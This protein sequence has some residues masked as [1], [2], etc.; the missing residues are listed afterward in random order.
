MPPSSKL[1]IALDN[2]ESGPIDSELERKYG[3]RLNALDTNGDGFVDRSELLSFIRD[4][5]DRE[6]KYKNLKLLMIVL[7]VL[8][9]L[10]ALTTFGTVWAVVAL[11]EKI[12][13]SDATGKGSDTVPALVSRSTGDTLR[14][15]MGYVNLQI[16]PRNESDILAYE[17]FT[18]PP[19]RRWL[20]EAYE[21]LGRVAVNDV[22]EGCKLLLEGKSS[23]MTFYGSDV[24]QVNVIS[25]SA[26]DCRKAINYE[27]SAGFQAHLSTETFGEVYVLCAALPNACSAFQY[28]GPYSSGRRL[29]SLENA[30]GLEA[31]ISGGHLLLSFGPSRVL[32][33]AP[34]QRCERIHGIEEAEY[35]PGR[36]LL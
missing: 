24:M 35:S 25:A 6:R 11:T 22:A 18:L 14:T 23:F 29:A 1:G 27:T 13:T 17:N 5:V 21:Y 30:R 20:A 26:E 19:Q 8:L 28:S 16:L 36:G 3:A 9:L 15:A 12:S 10:F 7:S 2:G 32:K 34:G 33:C 31:P 4:T